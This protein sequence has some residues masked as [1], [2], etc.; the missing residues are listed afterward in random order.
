MIYALDTNII[1]FLLRPGRNQDVVRQFEKMIEQGDDYVIPAIAYYEIMWYLLRKKA[2]GQLRV[3]ERLY[4]N[5]CVEIRMGEADF[6]LAARIKANLVKQ[7]IPLGDKDADI[8]ISAC[9]MAND[10]TLVTDNVSDFER[11]EG[12]KFVNWKNRG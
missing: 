8:L 10:Y 5:A 2:T 4:R 12:L 7:G 11:I 1:S 9:C 3:F 6:L